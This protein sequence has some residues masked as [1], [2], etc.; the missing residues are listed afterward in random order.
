MKIVIEY[1]DS[2]TVS[3]LIGDQKTHFNKVRPQA[4]TLDVFNRENEKFSIKK[5]DS[6]SRKI[7]ITNDTIWGILYRIVGDVRP[8]HVIIERNHYLKFLEKGLSFKQEEIKER[9]EFLAFQNIGNRSDS[10]KKGFKNPENQFSW[11]G[12][13]K[14]ETNKFF[15]EK[16]LYQIL[17][18][19]FLCSPQELYELIVNKKFG[20]T[21]LIFK[22]A[23]LRILSL[24]SNIKNNIIF[25]ENIEI[26]KEMREKIINSL[27]SYFEKVKYEESDIKKYKMFV[28]S[29]LYMCYDH[30]CKKYEIKEENGKLSSKVFGKI[31]TFQNKWSAGIAHRS[32]TPK[33]LI[34]KLANKTYII[35]YPVEDV[36]VSDGT[37][38]ID[39]DIEEKDAKQLKEMIEEA[40]VGVFRVGKKGTAY[41]KEIQI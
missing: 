7:K 25:S 3:N 41:I 38:I 32:I 9:S 40:N 22:D 20:K 6:F 39:C 4:K 11:R 5:E 28:Y 24:D 10:S 23:R 21:D 34:A 16:D 1:N 26:D 2:W 29:A 30:L 18:F 37:I 13:I 27:K 14:N 35:N 19:P 8:L 15:L 36:A 33:D 12:E 31:E 17:L